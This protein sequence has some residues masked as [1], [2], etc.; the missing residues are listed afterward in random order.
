MYDV[1]INIVASFI[2]MIIG[3]VGLT[4]LNWYRAKLPG[5]KIWQLKNPTNVVICL[6][7]SIVQK[8]KKPDGTYERPAT[9]IGQIRALDLIIRSLRKT[10]GDKSIHRIVLSHD[11]SQ[12]YF[13]DD[14]VIVGGALN[15]AI[16]I[17]FFEVARNLQP[18]YMPPIGSTIYWRDTKDGKWDDANQEAFE[19]KI[20]DGKVVEDCAVII[21]MPNP[22]TSKSRTILVL[23]GSHTYGTIAAAKY[24][25]EN[26]LQDLPNIGSKNFSVIVQTPIVLGYPARPKL[27]K[28]YIW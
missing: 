5:Q 4:L 16:A 2:W 28:N 11:W 22:F 25:A 24:L 15:N 17:K 3:A 13:D 12:D 6:A 21:R 26:L 18:A 7:T 20:V 23:C 9:G 19:G 1:A 8:V 10:Y 14:L 27:L